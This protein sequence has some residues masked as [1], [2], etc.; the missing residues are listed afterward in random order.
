M[1]ER[2]TEPAKLLD[3]SGPPSECEPW[4]LRSIFGESRSAEP[5]PFRQGSRDW[6]QLCER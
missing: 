3:R 2:A 1:S 6:Y 4:P 5:I